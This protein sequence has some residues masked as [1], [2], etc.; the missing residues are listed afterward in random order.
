MKGFGV[1]AY[2]LLGA[3]IFSSCRKSGEEHPCY[4]ASI[5]HDSPCSK[6]CPQIV[7]CDGQIYCNE[8]DAARS[9]ISP[10]Q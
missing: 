6:D 2:L 9:G 8:C 10:N 1:I 4:D 7:G 3:L 5:V